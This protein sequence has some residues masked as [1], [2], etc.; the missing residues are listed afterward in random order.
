M[1]EMMRRARDTVCAL[2]L[3]RVVWNEWTGTVWYR[4]YTWPLRFDDAVVRHD[5]VGRVY[6]RH[7]GRWVPI[8]A[9]GCGAARNVALVEVS[10]LGSL[11]AR[12]PLPHWMP[13]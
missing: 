2:R 4:R 10:L 3:Y 1:A 13:R 9:D 12:L 7:A 5:R 6:N 11:W 8:P